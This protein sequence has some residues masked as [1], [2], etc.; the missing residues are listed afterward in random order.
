LILAFHDVKFAL[1]V[2]MVLFKR[3]HLLA[4]V[5]KRNCDLLLDNLL[6]TIRVVADRFQLV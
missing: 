5:G 3:D 1:Q 4:L 6:N 2:V